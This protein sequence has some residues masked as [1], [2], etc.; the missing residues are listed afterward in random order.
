MD[1]TFHQRFTSSA[2]WGIALCSLLTLHFF[3]VQ[4]AVVGLLLVIVIVGMI[5][6]VLHTV[7]IFR[8]VKPIDREEEHEF[9]VIDKGRFAANVNIPLEEITEVTERKT[10]YGGRYLLIVYGPGNM[11]SVQPDNDKLFLE[12]LNK[13]RK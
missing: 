11:V 9:L 6:R 4:K 7:Y 12:E 2:K 3:W 10:R 8:R 5:D 13:R 1:R